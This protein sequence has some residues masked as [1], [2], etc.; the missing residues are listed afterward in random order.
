MRMKRKEVVFLALDSADPTIDW[1]M[2]EK[3]EVWTLN[4]Y[5]RVYP[6]LNP[7][8]VYQV[9]TN[10]D[11]NIETIQKERPERWQNWREK[12]NES[13]AKIVTLAND[14]KLKNQHDWQIGR[15]CNYPAG[16]FTQ[17][18]AYMAAD[19]IEEEYSKVTMMGFSVMDRIDYHDCFPSCVYIL[20]Y[21]MDK[22]VCVEAPIYPQWKTKQIKLGIE[23]R[24]PNYNNEI[25]GVTF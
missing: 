13:G 1:K 21:M 6:W 24:L 4:D 22:G 7:A 14:E 16:F 17:T 12:Y 10:I 9:H 3:S 19:A 5:Y 20:E 18:L 25:Y 15:I 23:V 8:R 2:L 11:L